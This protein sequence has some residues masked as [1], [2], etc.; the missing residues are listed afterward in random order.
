[1]LDFGY[2]LFLVFVRKSPCLKNIK[3][4]SK[5]GECSFSLRDLAR[6]KRLSLS[7]KSHLFILKWIYLPRTTTSSLA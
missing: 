2:V 3:D 5:A 1:M 7:K 6:L 4:F